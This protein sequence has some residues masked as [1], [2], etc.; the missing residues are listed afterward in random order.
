MASPNLDA[1]TPERLAGLGKIALAM[2]IFGIFIGIFS[3]DME[4]YYIAA[5]MIAMLFTVV[6]VWNFDITLIIY[7]LV[8]FIPWG[9]TPD[10]V[11]GGSG[12]GR[13]LY[14]SEIM[15]AFLLIVWLGRYFTGNLP[16]KRISTGF[17][18]PLTIYLIFC[19]VNVIN[20]FVFWDPNVD[21][22]NQ[23]IFAN[24]AEIAIHVLSGAALAI[25][26]TS[27]S[28][29]KTAIIAAITFMVTGLYNVINAFFGFI[30]PF[31]AVWYSLLTILPASFLLIVVFNNYY[32]KWF[33]FLAFIILCAILYQTIVINIQWVSG[34]F[35]LLVSLGTTAII[36]DK[37]VFFLSLVFLII[38]IIIFWPV[39]QIDIIKASEDEGDFHRFDMFFGSIRMA[40]KFPMGVGLGNY[41]T[42]II[43]YGDKLDIPTFTSAHGTYAQHIAE[44]GWLGFILFMNFAICSLVWML[45]ALKFL[46][47]EFVR[48]FL[49]AT[50][51]QFVGIFLAASI[52]DYIFPTYH[53][54]G[55]VTFSTTVQS[56]LIWGTAIA[57]VR[58]SGDY[59]NGSVNSDS[60]LEHKKNTL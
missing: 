24:L 2:V 33:R 37:K 49:I 15:L 38:A 10:I 25:T 9:R 58:L 19:I 8:S 28:S 48:T 41:R 44:M 55:L 17:Y 16:K 13:G 11:Q 27:F 23:K 3:V 6:L 53:N 22:A 59:K 46:K 57:L 21:K 45:K 54:G 26:A 51:G 14:V 36:Y 31:G 7:I 42:Y 30:V 1:I 43:K 35:A 5:A 20:S 32:N 29:M 40:K 34:Y 47:N 56:W 52:G 39:I 60:K 4:F 18:I 12:L 50:I